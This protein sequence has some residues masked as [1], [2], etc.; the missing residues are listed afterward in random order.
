LLRRDHAGD[1]VIAPGVFWAPLVAAFSFGLG[2]PL[3]LATPPVIIVL[4]RYRGEHVEQHAV[5]GFEHSAGE[6]IVVHFE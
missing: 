6:L 5:D 3:R 4:T 2:L 1:A